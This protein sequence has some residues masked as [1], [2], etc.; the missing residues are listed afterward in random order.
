MFLAALSVIAK[1]WKPPKCPSAGEQISQAWSIHALA[2]CT[3][4]KR[5]QFL[6]DEKIWMN[7]KTV[8]S[9]ESSQIKKKDMCSMI[10]FI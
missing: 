1:G 9:S 8:M 10:P 5:D 7:L 4:I 2:Y 6:I 3:A